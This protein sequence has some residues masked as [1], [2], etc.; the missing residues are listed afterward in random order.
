MSDKVTSVCSDLDADCFEVKDKH[1][2]WLYDMKRG[3]CPWLHPHKMFG[4]KLVSCRPDREPVMVH[5]D[6]RVEVLQLADLREIDR[7]R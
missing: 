4:G 1:H 7:T 5:E 3:Y 2:C 6:G